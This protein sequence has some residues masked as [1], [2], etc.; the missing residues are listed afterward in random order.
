MTIINLAEWKKKKKDNIKQY[1]V[2]GKK[3]NQLELSLITG[4]IQNNT[5]TL[6]KKIA[7]S[8]KVKI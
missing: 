7:V 6:E 3:M 4:G 1:K 2:L 8:Y 5:V